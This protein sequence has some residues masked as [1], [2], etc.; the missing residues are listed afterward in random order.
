MFSQGQKVESFVASGDLST[1]LNRIVD[2]LATDFK[3][4]LAGAGGGFGVLTNAPKN[5][6]HAAVATDG[7]VMVRVGAAITSGV[8]VTSAASGWGVGVTSGSGQAVIGRTETGAASGM[9]AA[10]KL[11]QF[12]RPN[13]VGN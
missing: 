7:V 3:I 6:E 12:Y 5:T 10:V 13:S 9:L 2:L 1:C 8:F 11:G 4:G